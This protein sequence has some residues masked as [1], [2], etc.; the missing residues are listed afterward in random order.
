MTPGVLAL[1]GR[2]GRRSWSS[3][4]RSWQMPWAMPPAC[5]GGWT[6]GESRRSCGRGYGRYDPHGQQAQYPMYAR[7]HV[8]LRRHS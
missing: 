1:N 3:S 2:A 8:A 7:V 5:A 4:K 6:A